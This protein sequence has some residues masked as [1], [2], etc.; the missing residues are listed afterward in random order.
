VILVCSAGEN[1]RRLASR[2]SSSLYFSKLHDVEILRST[3]R[4][5]VIRRF[6]DEA[7]AEMEIDVSELEPEDVAARILEVMASWFA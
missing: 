5:E 6:G 7:D 4:E 1:E 2:Q 3:R